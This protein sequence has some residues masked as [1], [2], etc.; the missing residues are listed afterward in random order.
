MLATGANLIMAPTN[1]LCLLAEAA[2]EVAK[3]EK[4]KKQKEAKKAKTNQQKQFIESTAFDDVVVDESSPLKVGRGPDDTTFLQSIKGVSPTQLSVC[5]LHH[6]WCTI[7]GTNGYK[8]QSKVMMC[9]LIINGMKLKT[10][11]KDMYPVDFS[12][13]AG[14]NNGGD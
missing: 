9:N 2:A 8:D 1:T 6:F 13:D 11:D 14:D 10:L 5:A 7:N 12:G 3:K 4:K